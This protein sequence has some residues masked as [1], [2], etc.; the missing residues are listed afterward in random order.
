MN[1]LLTENLPWKITSVILA[2]LLWLFVIN[3]QNPIQPQEISD[4][5]IVITGMADLEANG[6]RL[7]NEEEIK[8]QQF[9]VV[10]TGPRLEIDKLIRDT[11]LIT[12]TL[13]MQQYME[14]LNGNSLTDTANYTVKMDLDSYS[15]SVTDKKAQVDKVIIDKIDQK[16]QKVN[17]KIS[18]DLTDTYTLI[19]DETPVISPGK[20]II[21]GAKTDID[22]VSEAKVYLDKEDFSDEKLV[23]NLPVKLYDAEGAEISGLNIAP[24]FV[25]VK[26]PI[27]SE[28]EVP[29]KLN[30]IGELKEGLV[31]VNTIISP[32]KVRIIGRSEKLSGI[33]EIQLEPIDLTKITKTDLIETNMKLPEGVMTL[34]ESKV[35]I[36]LEIEEKEELKYPVQTSN[37]NLQVIGLTEGLSY[38]VLTPVIEVTLSAIP[39]KLLSYEKEDISFKLDLTG[40]SVGEYTLPL[41]AKTPEDITVIDEVINVDIK[42]DETG[43]VP[44]ETPETTPSIEPTQIPELNQD[45]EDLTE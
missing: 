11:G 16:E 2:F 21:T 36:S 14:D 45:E 39:N 20:V 30:Y 31:L 34:D 32:A 42:I 44:E 27:G 22:R 7:R 17:Y 25:E 43:K 1:K 33:N 12:V 9:K 24:E 19:D 4:V 29:V 23:A 40:Y 13:N 8:K 38:E 18:E 41:I 28:K 26:L 3:T 37:M 15:V 6:Y 10:V 35:R 5:N